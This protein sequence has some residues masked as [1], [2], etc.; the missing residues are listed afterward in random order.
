[1]ELDALTKDGRQITIE[2]RGRSLLEQGKF[3][4]TFHIARDVTER[5]QIEERLRYLGTH[6]VLTGLY[7]RAYF[8][9]EMTRLA[10]GR[11]FPVSIVMVDVNGLKETN[12]RHGH[13]AGDELLR[14]TARVLQDAFR[15]EDIVA[16][17]GGDE[18]AVLLPGVDQAAAREGVTRVRRLLAERNAGW[19][20]LPLGLALGVATGDA[21]GDLNA[22]LL[23]ADRRMYQTK[24][25]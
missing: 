3:A 9:A 2:V 13:A 17:I 4:G 8:E 6:D 16:R 24:R 11:Q 19:A 23:E 18:F 14:R 20:D 10:H 7:N 12:D 15:A 22:V 5:R 21:G 1:L 25:E